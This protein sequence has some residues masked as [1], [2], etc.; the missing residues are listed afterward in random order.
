[1][2]IGEIIKAKIIECETKIRNEITCAFRTNKIVVVDYG[3]QKVGYDNTCD[4][5]RLVDEVIKNNY[6]YIVE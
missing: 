6:P 3:V 2:N 4:I 1:M 5:A